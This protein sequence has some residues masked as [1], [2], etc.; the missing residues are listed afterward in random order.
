[1]H[2]MFVCP[3][4]QGEPPPPRGGSHNK[5]GSTLVIGLGVIHEEVSELRRI[6]GVSHDR[7]I[8]AGHR[9]IL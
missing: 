7:G 8:S 2:L 9:I 1:M 3:T 5:K 4:M 6:Q